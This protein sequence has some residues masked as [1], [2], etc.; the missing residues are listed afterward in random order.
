MPRQDN[1]RSDILAKQDPTFIT[2]RVVSFPEELILKEYIPASF[3][4]DSPDNIELHFYSIP[5]NAL[6][7]STRIDITEADVSILKTHVVSYADGTLKP[8]IRID[9]T[10]LFTKKNIVLLPGTYKL[11]INFFSD[12][13]GSYSDRRLY[14]QEI[15]DSRTELQLAFQEAPT[16]QVFEKNNYEAY[17]YVIPKYNSAQLIRILEQIFVKGVDRNDPS[18]GILYDSIVDVSVNNELIP[19]EAVNRIIRVGEQFN[20]D[21][22]DDINELLFQIFVELKTTISRLYP[23]E[24]DSRIVKQLIIDAIQ[25]AILENKTVD[26]RVVLS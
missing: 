11:V 4:F 26:R 21:L 7:L 5:N 19:Q 2:S 15:S 10:E 12:M 16:Q 13:V 18:V 23:L 17:E 24:I 25:Q 1:Y 3:G 14:I 22:R 9:F 20:N 8:Y 6:L